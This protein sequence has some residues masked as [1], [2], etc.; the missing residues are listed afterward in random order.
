MI[1]L[2][3]MPVALFA[4]RASRQWIVRDPKGNFWMLPSVEDPWDHRQPF[5]PTSEMDLEPVPGH[6]KNMLRLPF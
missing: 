1:L 5:N 6:H 3:Q 4:D 2:R